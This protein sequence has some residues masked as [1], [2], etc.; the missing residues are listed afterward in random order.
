MFAETDLAAI[1]SFHRGKLHFELFAGLHR[2]LQ[3]GLIGL[4]TVPTIRLM[5][6]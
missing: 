3:K 4:G 2:Y 1:A 5:G 6:E